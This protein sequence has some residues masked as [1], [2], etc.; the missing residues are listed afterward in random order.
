MKQL[1]LAAVLAVTL[2]GCAT[3][4]YRTAQAPKE[5]VGSG[6][7]VPYRINLHFDSKIPDVYSLTTNAAG[8]AQ[9]HRVNDGF[10]GE[11][12]AYAVEKSTSASSQTADLF[13]TVDDLK[14]TYQGLG[15]GEYMNP[16]LR[17][18]ATLTV[19]SEVRLGEK[20]L[21]RDQ[22]SVKSDEIVKPLD[23]SFQ[24]YSYSGLFRGAEQKALEKINDL[25]ERTLAQ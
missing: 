8:E 5:R 16:E 17:K 22:F 23:V 12:E 3:G 6:K 18:S 7:A 10:R 20:T 1:S 14:T 13:V 9:Q 25:I 15:G 21:A 4:S 11:L 2:A 19:T 24:S